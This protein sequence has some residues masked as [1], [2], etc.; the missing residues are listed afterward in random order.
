MED[1]SRA[2]MAAFDA[3]TSG[4]LKA[5][6]PE[7]QDSDAVDSSLHLPS[8]FDEEVSTDSSP[9]AMEAEEKLAP[10]HRCLMQE[11]IGKPF[12]LISSS[13]SSSLV[14]PVPIEDFKLAN[15]IK[16]I[17]ERRILKEAKAVRPSLVITLRVP[18]ADLRQL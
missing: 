18:P 12:K 10:E 6:E 11:S 8:D 3:L 14:Q 5:A 4:F 9:K 13:V 2:Y 15:T 16:A 7:V 1:L 17:E